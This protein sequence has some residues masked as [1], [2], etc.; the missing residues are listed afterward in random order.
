L[1]ANYTIHTLFLVAKIHN[2]QALYFWVG[3]LANYYD[4]SDDV[5]WIGL[6]T[7][8]FSP[9]LIAPCVGSKLQA[10][11]VQAFAMSKLGL[12]RLHGLDSKPQK[13]KTLFVSKPRE[14]GNYSVTLGNQ[15]PAEFLESFHCR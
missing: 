5:Y 14:I 8:V 12:T 3:L 15:S 4:N 7:L 11:K 10:A 2:L 13:L 1:A 6:M 9:Q